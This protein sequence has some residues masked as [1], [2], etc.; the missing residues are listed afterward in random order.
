MDR[1]RASAKATARNAMRNPSVTPASL[2][3]TAEGD[4]LPEPAVI[5]STAADADED[6]GGEE[7]TTT[8]GK[9]PTEGD[10]DPSDDDHSDSSSKPS[11]KRKP[12]DDD[13]YVDSSPDEESDVESVPGYVPRSHN[14]LEDQF[15][16]GDRY[17]KRQEGE[18]RIRIAKL[19]QRD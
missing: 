3:V 6:A 12:N 4:P 13:S 7:G 2:G 14:T 19:A 8:A 16:S 11:K 10:P 17:K 5:D 9:E 18:E 15:L 1:K